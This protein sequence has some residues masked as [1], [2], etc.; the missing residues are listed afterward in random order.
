MSHPPWWRSCIPSFPLAPK[1]CLSSA[2]RA[3]ANSAFLTR[4]G[5]WGNFDPFLWL[6]SLWGRLV[7]FSGQECRGSPWDFWRASNRSFSSPLA[8]VPKLAQKMSSELSS[9]VGEVLSR[10]GSQQIFMECC[11]LHETCT[12][13]TTPRHPDAQLAV[14]L[15]GMLWNVLT[16]LPREGNTAEGCYY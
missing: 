5:G 13:P 11:L 16:F 12:P 14:E 8:T 4:G 9:G 1:W 10:V 15:H 7:T 2:A 6:W 3:E